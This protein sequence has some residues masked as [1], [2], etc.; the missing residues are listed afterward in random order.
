MM[1]MNKRTFI[2][3]SESTMGQQRL[4]WISL[5]CMENDNLNTIDFNYKAILCKEISQIFVLNT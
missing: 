2:F 3:K 4:N 1:M 5:M